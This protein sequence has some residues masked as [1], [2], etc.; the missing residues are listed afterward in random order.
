M[1]FPIFQISSFILS[2]F[3]TNKRKPILSLIFVT[4]MTTEL[5]PTNVFDLR[6]HINSIKVKAK[7][8]KII[9]QNIKLKKNSFNYQKTYHHGKSTSRTIV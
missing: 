7:T 8:Q 2:Y 1:L 5:K 3:K 4:P 9:N 6:L